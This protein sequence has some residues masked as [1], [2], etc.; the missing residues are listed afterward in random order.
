[1]VNYPPSKQIEHIA[2][3]L[4]AGKIVYYHKKT[5]EI[6]KYPQGFEDWLMDDEENP[7]QDV[8]DKVEANS[9]DYVE[10]EPM[11][12]REAYDIMKQFA[13]EK[14]DDPTIKLLAMDRL[15]GPKPFRRFKDLVEYSDYREEW[16]A[17][18]QKAHEEYVR[19]ILD[20]E[21]GEDDFEDDTE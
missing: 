8:L 4:Q 6:L 20:L 19:R 17:F 11:P 1:M 3:S 9:E 12:S 14:I 10:I 5:G 18:R 16:F 7:F 2:Q 21:L 13:E 15:T